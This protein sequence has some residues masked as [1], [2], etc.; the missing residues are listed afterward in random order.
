MLVR[1]PIYLTRLAR[2]PE[3]VRGLRS[4]LN[5][6][7]PRGDELH[8]R[9]LSRFELA[10]GR[11]RLHAEIRT[12][13]WSTALISNIGRII[14]RRWRGRRRDRVVRDIVLQAVQCVTDGG[15]ISKQWLK[16]FE[17][18]NEMAIDGS[19]HTA[20]AD[21]LRVVVEG[22]SLDAQPSVT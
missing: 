10:V 9:F 3:I 19:I 12:S 4:R 11:W 2:S 5:V 14:P 6:R 17:K 18:L 1:D 15:T 20:S 16:K 8:R 7:K 13:D 21:E 22:T